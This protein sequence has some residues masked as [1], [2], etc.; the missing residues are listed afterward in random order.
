[1]NI[2][3]TD[4]FEKGMSEQE[5]LEMVQRIFRETQ[6]KAEAKVKAQAAAQRA[7]DEAKKSKDE[8]ETLKAEARAYAI[9]A[10]IA[11]TEAFDLLPEGETIDDEDVAELEKL[12]IRIEN[13]I[14]LYFK[15]F[16]MHEDM[17]NDLGFGLGGLFK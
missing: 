3:F 11:Y 13:M 17:D 16:Q 5:A 10:L 12:L 2:D 15:L 9:N 8:K 6:E 1:M 7:K 4:A 14:P